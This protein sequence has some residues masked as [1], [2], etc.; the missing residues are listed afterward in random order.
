MV[1]TPTLKEMK[2]RPCTLEELQAALVK[3]TEFHNKHV[4][5]TA[6]KLKQKQDKPWTATM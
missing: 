1:E 5:L 4:E 2:E 6:T 3:L